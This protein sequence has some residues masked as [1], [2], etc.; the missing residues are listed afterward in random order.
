MFGRQLF[1]HRDSRNEVGVM[2]GRPKIL[3]R[4]VLIIRLSIYCALFVSIGSINGNVCN[5]IGNNDESFKDIETGRIFET[6]NGNGP[7]DVSFKVTGLTYSTT[8]DDSYVTPSNFAFAI[9]KIVTNNTGVAW[10]YFQID[11]NQADGFVIKDG[12][13]SPEDASGTFKKI[14][15]NEDQDALI[16]SDG[17]LELGETIKVRLI[18]NAP[19]LEFGRI[20]DIKYTFVLSQSSAIAATVT[21][22]PEPGSL[23][24]LSIGILCVRVVGKLRSST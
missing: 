16:F 23:A 10:T 17:V 15:I 7:Y 12:L 5:I 1:L 4:V 20:D 22:V 19:K 3:Y 6:I 18:I 24:L 8:Q 14:S 13:F 11:L 9:D 2:N 21:R